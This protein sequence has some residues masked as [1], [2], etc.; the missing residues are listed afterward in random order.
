[1]VMLVVVPQHD[2]AAELQMP[3]KADRLVVD[4]FHQAAVAG[5]HLGAVVDQIVAVDG[6]EV[7]LGDRHADRHRQA[8]PQRPGGRLDPGEHEILR[9]GRRTGWRAGGS[10][11]CRRSS[12]ARSRSGGAARRSA[13]SRGRPTGR[14]GRGRANA[15]RPGSNF[16]CRVN[17]AVATSAMPIG[18]PG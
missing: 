16:R 1:M 17:R 13:S 9:D 6:V 11:G 8:L 10:C 2:Q 18:M 14:S 3:G 7:A 12:A 15:D 4:A 5:D